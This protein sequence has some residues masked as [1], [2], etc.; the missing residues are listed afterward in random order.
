MTLSEFALKNKHTVYALAIAAIFFG[1]LS[2]FSLPIQ[3]FPET[4]PPLVNILTPYPGAAAEDVADMVSDPI[5]EECAALEGVYKVSSSSQ[6]GLSLVTVEFRYDVDVDMAALDAQN[7]ISRIREQLPAGI[8]EPQVLKFST[9]DRPVLTVGITG[10][11]L[12]DVR[13]LAEEKLAPE[14]QRVEGVALVDVFGGHEPELSVLL[15]RNRLEAYSLPIAAVANAIKSHNI[16]VPAGKI[17][18]EESQYSFRID[19]ESKTIQDIENIPIPL[20]DG[21]R[22]LLRDVAAIR[23]GSAEDLSKYHVNGQAAIAVQIFKQDDANTVDVVSNAQEKFDELD[24]RYPQLEFIEAEESASF[25]RQVV[26]NMFG[27]VAQALLLAAVIIFLFLGSLRRAVVVAISMPMSFLLTFAGMKFFGI[28]IDLVTLTAIILAVGMVI[29]ASVVVLE[30]IARRYQL[31]DLT[32]EEAARV[33]ASEIQFAIIAGNATTLTVLIPLL[34]LYGFVGKT[35]GPLAATLIIA[36]LSSLLVALVMVP[37]LTTFTAGEGGR[38]ERL[39]R[40]ISGPWNWLMDRVRMA[41]LFL[42]TYSLSHRWAVFVSAVI[43][44]FAGLLLLRNQGTE[45]LPKMD[46]GTSF[47]T[48]ETTSGTSLD[49][50]E[51]IVKEV[52]EII[53]EEP[54]VLLVSTQ[55][56]F[57]PGMHSFGGGGVQ[58]PTQGYISITLSPRTDR[59]ETI[60]EIQDRIREKI[61]KIPGIE[62]LVVRESGSTARSTTASS[63]VVSIRG[64]D[65]LVL[66]QLGDQVL[67]AISIVPSV[68]NPYRSWRR[69]QRAVYLNVNRERALDLAMTPLGLSR[70]L[71]YSL[72]GVMAGTFEGQDGEQTPIRVRYDR[73]YRATEPDAYAVRAISPAGETSIPVSAIINGREATVQGLVTRENLQPTLDILALH[74]GRPLNFVA[75]DVSKAVNELTIPQGYTAELLGEDKDM[76]ESR[77]ELVFALV[78]AFVTVYLLLVAQFRSFLHPVTVLMSIPLSLIGV[79]IALWVAGKAVS[80]PVMV[81]LILLI[82]ILVNNSIILIDLIRQRRIDGVGRREAIIES[83]ET[84]F[85]PIMMTSFSTIVGMIPLAM[86]WA[87]GAERFS[88]LAIAVIGGMTAS[89]LLT[90]IVIPIIYDWLDDLQGWFSRIWKK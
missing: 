20:H 49:H 33:G 58:G 71:T 28:Q 65:P 45:L 24:H 34:F 36:F 50:T 67:N 30:N 54:G 76:A 78:I 3:L 5:E 75:A 25:T 4:A 22:L 37:I 56:G 84:R 73:R 86:E 89:T 59:N 66:D 27:S 7:A 61:K 57:E 42:L 16:S 38:F 81:G 90:M 74:Q 51:T 9:S 15:D 31:E 23:Y 69:D 48:V 53:L 41:Y 2:Y 70:D 88:P 52:E 18:S 1:V 46:S 87:L 80:M 29:D 10:E 55:I 44:L 6:D 35:F 13:R 60:W 43:L 17:N 62:N 83:V 8:Q 26:S 14:L 21:S 40:K 12:T 77:S 47:V 82:G 68:V 64:D 19:E 11:N 39:S 85:R 79:G 32:P 63:I 72:D